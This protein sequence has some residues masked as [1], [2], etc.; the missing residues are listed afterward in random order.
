MA[1]KSSM[2]A[3]PENI[4]LKPSTGLILL[5]FGFKGSL[6][7]IKPVCAML[8]TTPSTIM[9]TNMGMVILK[10]SCTENINKLMTLPS[11][12]LEVPTLLK[13]LER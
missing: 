10:N 9:Q 3:L 5:S 8:A 6:E 13:E 12:K 11:P 1:F 4:R 2:N 7:N